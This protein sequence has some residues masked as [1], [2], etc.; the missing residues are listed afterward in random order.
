MLRSTV[1]AVLPA[2]EEEAHHRGCRCASWACALE[3][4]SNSAGLCPPMGCPPLMS[5][6][7]CVSDSFRATFKKN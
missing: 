5:L 6:G 4:H 2:E 1:P 7:E 3:P